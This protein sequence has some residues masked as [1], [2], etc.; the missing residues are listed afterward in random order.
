MRDPNR[1]T[2][3]ARAFVD[4]LARAGI[5]E[6]CV[7]SG[8]RCAPLVLAF[9][10]DGRFRLFPH[11]DERSAAFF[12][13]GIARA[14]VRPAA[15]VTTS[16]TA[17]ANLYPA[18]VEAS[19]AEVP[20]LVLTADRPGHLRGLDANQT[21]DQDRLYGRFVRMF[22]DVGSPRVREDLVRH[23]RGLAHRA[24]AAATGIPPGP[25]HLNLPFEKPLEPVLVEGDV[26]ED[27]ADREPLAARGRGE[28]RPFTRVWGGAVRL[29]PEALRQV[30]DLMAVAPR[31]LIVCG[32]ARDPGRVGPA[33]LR[34]AEATGYPVLAD[35]L[36][37][38][39]F[40]PGAE[41]Q[42]VAGFDL[43]LRRADLRGRLRPDLILRLGAAPTSA[44]LLAF[45][46]ECEASVQ[47]A[48]DP[49][50]RWKDHLARADHYVRGDPVETCGELAARVGRVADPDWVESWAEL[51]ARAAQAVDE[52]L[53]GEFF[54]GAAVARV[55]SA[56]PAGSTLFIG[57]SM[58][59]R[60]LDA[61]TRPATA[62]GPLCVLGNRG[63]S[64]IDGIVSTA[65]GAASV[66]EGRTVAL[67]GDLSLCHDMN[68]LLAVRRAGLDLVLVVIHNDGGG[69]FE[70]L[71]IRE[72]TEAVLPY[73]IMPHGLDFAAAARLY[74]LPF[75]RTDS[76]AELEGSL[77]AA[78]GR[79]GP[80]I[81]EVVS[82]RRRNRLRHEEAAARV[83][84]AVRSALDDRRRS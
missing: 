50:G 65:A 69:I 62:A 58:P 19:Q 53:A 46:D 79:S 61:F 27:F 16:G 14:A 28:G 75:V 33:A 59:I 76:A 56:M 57:N 55:V 82:D 39:R 10:R 13:V 25:V 83:G 6:V 5:R 22:A 67:M 42:V 84:D 63:A 31:G 24:V 51:S 2:V 47:V 3:W 72:Q 78:L 21:I 45:L 32:P 48:V 44:S 54:E 18:V 12:A 15:V 64:G 71:P 1:N 80:A 41:R 9:V 11:L 36:S 68:G 4:E 35:P 43:F 34:L 60:D 20:L 23:V 49:G 8:S 37:G 74:E 70:L 52:A 73:V 30:A 7:T 66:S 17:A 77:E 81:I 29:A 40:A 26:P 38:A